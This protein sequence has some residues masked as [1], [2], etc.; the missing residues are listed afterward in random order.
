M[1]WLRRAPRV[2]FCGAAFLE[3]VVGVV[4]A[5]H[6]P[7]LMVQAAFRHMGR[8][9]QGGKLGAGSAPEVMDGERLQEV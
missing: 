4:R 6:A 7:Q 9:A 1:D 5:F 2:V 8:N 3:I